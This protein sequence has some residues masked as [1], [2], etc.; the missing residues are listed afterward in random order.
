MTSYVSA[1]LRRQVELRANGCCE[2][3]QIDKDDAFVGCQI[4]HVIAEKHGGQTAIE[5]LCFACAYCNRAKGSD[6]GSISALTGELTRLFNPRA[7]VWHEHFEIVG[8]EIKGHTTIGE[9]TAR[10]LKFND[11]DRI[12]ERMVLQ[13]IGRF[14]PTN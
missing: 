4:D 8:F 1:E 3:C 7:D 14:P 10:I 12:F 2:Y 11:D 9:A 5:N 13:Q 6:V